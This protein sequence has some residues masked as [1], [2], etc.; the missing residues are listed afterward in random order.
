VIK[1]PVANIREFYQALIKDAFG[2]LMKP[3]LTNDVMGEKKTQADEDSILTF[4][5]NLK[6][7]L[8]SPP[9]G[10]KPTLGVDPGFR[11]GC[12]VAA[13]DSTG[14]FLDYQ[15]IFPHQSDGSGNRRQKPWPQ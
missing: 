12:K 14:K 3:S 8:L 4:E 10:M 5:A 9:A 15:A 11:T 2:R 6:N 1:T 7:L 13:V